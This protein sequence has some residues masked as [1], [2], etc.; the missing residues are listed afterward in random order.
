[1]VCYKENRK[2]EINLYYYSDGK[3]MKK[4]EKGIKFLMCCGV[5]GCPSIKYDGTNVLI[6]D[7]YGN[8]VQLSVR[9]W[10]YLV[11]KIQKGV[12]SSISKK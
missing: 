2:V 10:N 6:K 9:E 4:F 11:E 7:D 5:Q 12:L 8:K 1:M 3:Y